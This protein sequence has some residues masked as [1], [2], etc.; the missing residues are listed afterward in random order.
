[1][2]STPSLASL[3]G[4]LWPGVVAP[5]S[6]QSICQIELFDTETACKQMADV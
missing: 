4:P 3:S 6:V 5:E 1:M 2:W